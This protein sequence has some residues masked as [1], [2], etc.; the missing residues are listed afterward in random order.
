MIL[1]VRGNRGKSTKEVNPPK[2]SR[3]EQAQPRL[4]FVLARLF[5]GLYL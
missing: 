4:H 3:Y 5:S 2:I 1:P